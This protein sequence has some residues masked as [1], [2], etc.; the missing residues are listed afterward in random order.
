MLLC[1]PIAGAA[2]FYKPEWFF[3]AMMLVIAGRYLTFC[4]LYGLRIYWV[5]G[6]AL[7]ASSYLLIAFEAASLVGAFVGGAVELAFA[8]VIFVYCKKYDQSI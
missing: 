6:I 5:F 8:V 3:P 2:S 1:I 4:T 7:A